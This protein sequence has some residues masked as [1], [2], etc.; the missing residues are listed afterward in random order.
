MKLSTRARY[1]LRMMIAIARRSNGRRAMS[2][3]AVAEKTMISRRYLEQLAIPL[4]TATLIRGVSGRAGGYRLARP[5]DQIRLGDI[6]EAAIGPI[7]IVDCVREPEICI[8]ADICE[9]RTVYQLINDGITNVLNSIYLH[10]MAD[11][12]KLS[13]VC[14]TL[15]TKNSGCPTVTP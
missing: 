11:E 14:N 3:A 6:V 4:K 7:N 2:L 8:K 9:C 5:P 13:S 10:Q 15:D 12:S 1:A